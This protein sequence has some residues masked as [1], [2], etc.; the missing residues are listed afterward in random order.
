MNINLNWKQPIPTNLDGIFGKDRRASLLYRE[1]IYRACNKDQTV[2]LDNRKH[3]KLLRGQVL[4]GRNKFAEYLCHDPRTT[5]RCLDRLQDNYQLVTNQKS[6]DYTI[7]TILSYDSIVAFDQPHDQ[8]VTNQSPTSV[9]PVTTS[10]SV[11]VKRVKSEKNNNTPESE[12]LSKASVKILD[13][14]GF[15]EELQK[16]F[17]DAPIGLEVRSMQDWLASKGRK[18]KDYQAFARNWLRKKWKEKLPEKMEVPLTTQFDID[19]GNAKESFTGFYAEQNRD[20]F[21]GNIMRASLEI[22]QHIQKL[23][24][25]TWYELYKQTKRLG[26]HFYKSITY[27]V[28]QNGLT[29]NEAVRKWDNRH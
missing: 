21:E 13:D 15:R 8:P 1:L 19:F 22:M 2:T 28:M 7:V 3:I 29:Y 14:R 27:E 10:K 6:H 24:R 23:G 11:R 12:T 20:R 16:R 18:Y 17:P 4:F 9:Q 26:I 25:E 5:A